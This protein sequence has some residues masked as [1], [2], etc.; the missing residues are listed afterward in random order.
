MALHCGLQYPK[1]LG[2]IFAL[3]GFLFPITHFGEPNEETPIFIAHGMK[4]FVIKFELSQQ[5]YVRLMEI[6]MEK[7]LLD[8]HIE[9]SGGHEVPVTTLIRIKE[10]F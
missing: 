8:L 2:G 3:S 10:F 7:N 4:D 1:R 9:P 6:K 5:S